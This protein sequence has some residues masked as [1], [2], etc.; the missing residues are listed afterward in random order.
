[1]KVFCR[2]VHFAGRGKLQIQFPSIRWVQEVE[3]FSLTSKVNHVHAPSVDSYEKVFTP[4]CVEKWSG[5]TRPYSDFL[6]GGRE[7]SPHPFSTWV[8]VPLEIL[9]YFSLYEEVKLCSWKCDTDNILDFVTSVQ[10]VLSKIFLS[11]VLILSRWAREILFLYKPSVIRWT[12]YL[13][14]C[15]TSSQRLNLVRNWT[16]KWSNWDWEIRNLR[17]G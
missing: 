8:Y 10:K 12:E 2:G 15:C 17:M 5:A 13:V 9:V 16:S 7:F 14:F 4:G 11:L 3:Q 1:M 6:G